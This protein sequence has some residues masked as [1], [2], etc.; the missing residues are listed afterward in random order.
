M[1]CIRGKT[2]QILA[3]VVLAA[4]GLSVR[5]DTIKDTLDTEKTEFSKSQESA[6]KALLSAFD[7]QIKNLSQAGDLDTVERL[8]TERKSFVTSKA[9]PNQSV[10]RS[11][12][13]QYSAS[14]VLAETRLKLAYEG[15]QAEYTKAGKI[16]DADAIKRAIADRFAATKPSPPEPL[17]VEYLGKMISVPQSSK[18]PDGSLQVNGLLRSPDTFSVPVKITALVNMNGVDT[19]IRFAGAQFILNWGDK[20]TELRWTGFG[21]ADPIGVPGKGDVARGKFATVEWD[22]DESTNILKVDGVVRYVSRGSHIGLGGDFVIA[23]GK[24]ITVKSIKVTQLK[25][26]GN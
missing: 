9:L 19:R 20:P 7:L 11:A 21:F 15:A 5:G 4:F 10:M 6:E 14:L 22:I 16:E 3:I 25:P 26:A 23:A 1:S 17:P 12:A 18:L 24:P 8:I 2:V 13:S